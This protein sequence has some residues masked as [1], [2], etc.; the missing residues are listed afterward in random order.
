M[1]GK[2]IGDELQWIEGEKCLQRIWIDEF[3]SLVSNIWHETE[4][5]DAKALIL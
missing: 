1:L 5:E 4:L 3:I 2:Q